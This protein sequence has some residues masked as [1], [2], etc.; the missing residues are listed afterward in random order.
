MVRH[1]TQLSLAL[2]LLGVWLPFV[3]ACHQPERH[4]EDIAST[5]PDPA[6]VQVEHRTQYLA[7]YPCSARCHSKR[8]VNPVQRQLVDFH[9]VRNKELHHGDS[10]AWC[11]QCHSEGNIDRLVIANGSLVTFDEAYLLC[12]SCHGDKLRDWKT[13]VHGKTMGN[14]TGA[15]TR[16]SCTACHNPHNPPFSKL[17][18]EASP[19]PPEKAGSL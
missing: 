14:W 11:Y 5:N 6:S 17:E 4:R 16:R 1:L 12:G 7:T 13:A 8:A 18:P 3:A 10:K 2:A 15:Q 9:S 19:V